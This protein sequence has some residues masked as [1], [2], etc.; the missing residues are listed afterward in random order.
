MPS[1]TEAKNCMIGSVPSS[2]SHSAF[3]CAAVEERLYLPVLMTSIAY[4]A[5]WT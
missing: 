3:I 2:L 5:A 1:E 4:S